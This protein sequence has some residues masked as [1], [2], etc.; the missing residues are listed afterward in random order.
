MF[1]YRGDIKCPLYYAEWVKTYEEWLKDSFLVLEVSLLRKPF[2]SRFYRDTLWINVKEIRCHD[3][4][5]KLRETCCNGGRVY[6]RHLASHEGTNTLN[7]CRIYGTFLNWLPIAVQYLAQRWQEWL[8]LPFHSIAYKKMNIWFFFLFLDK[9]S[10]SLCK[11]LESTKFNYVLSD[12][13]QVFWAAM[14]SVTSCDVCKVIN[15]PSFDFQ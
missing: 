5:I 9:Y 10:T 14:S 3:R 12:D 11:F 6:L 8:H 7:T 13:H 4:R 15:V 2:Y 1:H